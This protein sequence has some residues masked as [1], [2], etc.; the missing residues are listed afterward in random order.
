M[1]EQELLIKQLRTLKF[2]EN[3]WYDSQANGWVCSTCR[4]STASTKIATKG[5]SQ[6]VSPSTW[7]EQKNKETPTNKIKTEIEDEENSEEN[8]TDEIPDLAEALSKSPKKI[9]REYKHRESSSLRRTLYQEQKEQKAKENVRGYLWKK[10]YWRRNWLKRWFEL[11]EAADELVYFKEIKSGQRKKRNGI[12]LDQILFIKEDENPKSRHPHCFHVATTK[13]SWK[14]QAQTAE[15]RIKWISFLRSSKEQVKL[16]KIKKQNEENSNQNNN[17]S[18]SSGGG[19]GGSVAQ[20]GLG[21]M[22]TGSPASPSSKSSWRIFG[23]HS[24]NNNYNNSRSSHGSRFSFFLYSSKSE[25][26]KLSSQQMT[27]SPVTAIPLPKSDINEK[28][29]PQDYEESQQS[30]VSNYSLTTSTRDD[31]ARTLVRGK[32]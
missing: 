15:D 13:R 12:R 31:N 32:P 16:L 22:Q 4:S 5:A 30:T 18:G 8:D 2:F 17:G 28:E 3:F 11:N 26:L 6:E 24:N 29:E 1:E 25:K 20:T 27:N 9:L 7:S 10:G 21:T 14:F 19:P 23:G